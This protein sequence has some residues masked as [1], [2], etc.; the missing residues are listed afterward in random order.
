MPYW[1]IFAPEG[2]FTADD[3]QRLSADLAQM[4]ND[5]VDIPLFYTVVRFQETP[6]NTLYVGGKPTTNFI[7]IVVDHIARH[8]PDPDYRK[9]AMGVFEETIAP[10]V[11]DRGFDWEIHFDETPLDL[12]R[13]QGLVSPPGGSEMEK[14]WTK[15]NRA[16]P[17]D[18]DTLLSL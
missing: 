10:Y 11:R 16:I 2:A 3:K 4:Y 8:L 18:Y 1:E 14:L 13:V 17:Y 7:R 5:N 6:A 12:W 15:E 9:F